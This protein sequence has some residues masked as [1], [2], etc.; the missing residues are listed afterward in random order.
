MSKER[1]EA[2]KKFHKAEGVL[3][4]QLAV[5]GDEI[6]KREKYA[7]VELCGMDALH[8]YL[9]HKFH[10]LPKDVRVMSSEDVRFVLLKEMSGWTL[11]QEAR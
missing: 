7:D 6:A 3:A 8:F 11:P 9:I 10:W 2:L 1:Y 4:Y 5:F